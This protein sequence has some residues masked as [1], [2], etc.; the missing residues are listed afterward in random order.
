MLPWDVRCLFLSSKGLS[1]ST[2]TSV[3]QTLIWCVSLKSRNQ[4]RNDV[5]HVP[6]LT[7]SCEA[8]SQTAC[9]VSVTNASMSHWNCTTDFSKS[10]LVSFTLSSCSSSAI[11]KR[12]AAEAPPESDLPACVSV[13]ELMLHSQVFSF[14]FVCWFLS[15]PSFR[16][17]SG[18][19][20][21]PASRARGGSSSAASCLR[22]VGLLCVSNLAAAICPRC[23]YTWR[24]CGGSECG[25]AT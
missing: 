12:T 21:S 14:W 2:G 15:P 17:L 10:R 18:G 6:S 11:T 25:R 19:E 24:T 5:P 9:W 22:V 23:M 13:V 3:C 1:V 8:T 16:L 7:Y 4:F 20:A